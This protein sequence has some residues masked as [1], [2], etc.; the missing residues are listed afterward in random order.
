MSV[1]VAGL[2]VTPSDRPAA[3]G[4]PVRYRDG[5]RTTSDDWV[6]RVTSDH[7]AIGR[8]ATMSCW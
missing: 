1:P 4:V 5:G 2:R 8:L 7:K 3:C 6:V